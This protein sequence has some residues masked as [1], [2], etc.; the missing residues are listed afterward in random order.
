MQNPLEHGMHLR[1]PFRRYSKETG[2]IYLYVNN[3][4]NN[5]F[6]LH[7]NINCKCTHIVVL[8]RWVNRSLW[9]LI[10]LDSRNLTN[11]L[12][13][14]GHSTWNIQLACALSVRLWIICSLRILSLFWIK[15]K[16]TF[17]I[18]HSQIRRR[19]RVYH[20][21]RCFLNEIRQVRQV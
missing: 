15:P 2:N 16:W 7:N 13:T 5:S 9:R 8:I 21:L 6:W 20:Y 19:K 12:L 10:D 4:M 1:I 3:I 11:Q 17:W 14:S 18:S